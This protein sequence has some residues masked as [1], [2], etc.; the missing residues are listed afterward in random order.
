MKTNKAPTDGDMIL[1][2]QAIRLSE[3]YTRENDLEEGYL[4]CAKLAHIDHSNS[5]VIF[6]L[7]KIL[8]YQ[9]KTREILLLD[10]N[11]EPISFVNKE[12]ANDGLHYLSP[13]KLLKKFIY[14]VYR[15]TGLSLKESSVEIVNIGG[16]Q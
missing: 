14:G 12:E 7:E 9:H 2:T 10:N 15:D 4:A 1:I 16:L 6:W 3:R 8:G 5:D 13:Q 11:R